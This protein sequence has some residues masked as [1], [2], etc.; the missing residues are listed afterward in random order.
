MIEL[1]QQRISLG[2]SRLQQ[3]SERLPPLQPS[4]SRSVGTGYVNDQIIRVR[5][6]LP[7]AASV[8][9]NL[10]G[11]GLVLAKINSENAGCDGC[12]LRS[13]SP[14]GWDDGHR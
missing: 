12:R 10:V 13:A 5:P 7:D 2:D 3:S 14:R 6:E 1:K 9:G 8:V 4:K 11:A